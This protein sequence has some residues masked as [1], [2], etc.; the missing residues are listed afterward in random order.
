[1]AFDSA[2]AEAAGPW[3]RAANPTYP[4]LIDRHHV[5]AALYGMVNVPQA[6]WI[7]EDGNV[8]R[9]T[10]TAG[11]NDAFRKM[12]RTTG[13]LPED[14]RASIR[15]V[16]AEYLDA[17]RD[18]VEKGPAS[19]FALPAG[20]RVARTPSLTGAHALATAEFMMGDYLVHSGAGE[21]AAAHFSEAQRLWPENWTFKRQAW[22]LEDPA[23]A[24]GPEFWAAVEALG[25]SHYYEPLRLRDV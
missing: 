8:V 10:E 5:V 22:A 4:C 21:L 2:G 15:A 12:D 24:G 9:P 23:K 19:E 7:D 16:R 14:D 17:L 6:V 18:W 11:T 20:S 13:A 3:I 1:V 25:A